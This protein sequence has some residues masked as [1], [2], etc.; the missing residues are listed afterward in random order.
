LPLGRTRIR[1]YDGGMFVGPM[2]NAKTNM[3]PE[4]TTT[5]APAGD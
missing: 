5:L 3:I 4:E 1:R 2:R